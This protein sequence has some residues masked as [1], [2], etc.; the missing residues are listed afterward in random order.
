VPAR[1]R[2]RSRLTAMNESEDAAEEVHSAIMRTGWDMP[3]RLG[4]IIDAPR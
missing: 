2:G 4:G 1:S 3:P